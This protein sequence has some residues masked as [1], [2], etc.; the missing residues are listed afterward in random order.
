M[1]EPT[2]IPLVEILYFDGCPN[3]ETA[4]AMVDRVKGLRR[5]V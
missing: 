3:Y 5:R 1:A 2:R 4:R